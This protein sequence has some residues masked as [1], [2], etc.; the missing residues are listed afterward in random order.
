MTNGPYKLRTANEV[1]FI[2]KWLITLFSPIGGVMFARPFRAFTNLCV[3]SLACKQC[4]PVAMF[5]QSDVF[6]VTYSV[7][8]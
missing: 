4:V 6:S 2:P 1:V 3:S 7:S 8:R 5:V